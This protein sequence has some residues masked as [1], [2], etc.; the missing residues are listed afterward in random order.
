ME[1]PI[2]DSESVSESEP[3]PVAELV[4]EATEEID[5]DDA[6]PEVVESENSN[7]RVEAEEEV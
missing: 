7:T 2:V 3:E 4:S 1:S 5:E 6:E